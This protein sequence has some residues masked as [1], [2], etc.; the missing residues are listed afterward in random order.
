M[1]EIAEFMPLGS[2]EWLE[3]NGLGGWSSSTVSGCHTRR[4]HGLLVA[5]TEPPTG[6]MVLVSKLDETIRRGEEEWELGTSDYNGVFH[7]TGHRYWTGFCRN[8]H[9]EFLCEAGDVRIRKSVVMLHGENTV[10]LRYEV[11][12]AVGSFEL[13]FSPLLASRGYHQLTHANDAVSPAFHFE[14]GVFHAKLYQGTPEIYIGV[15]GSSFVSAPCWYYG[16]HYAMEEY[17]GLDCRE[18][19]FSPGRFAVSL[20][21]GDVLDVWLSTGDLSGRDTGSLLENELVRRQQLLDHQPAAGIGRKLALAADQFVV[22]RGDEGRTVIAGYHWFTDWGRDTMISLPGLCLSTGRYDEA[23][24]VLASFARSASRGMLPNRFPDYGEPPEYNNV[25]G[26]LWYFIAV[27]HYLEATGDNEFVLRELL[28]G[29]KD[30]VDWHFRGTRYN[31]HV[32]DSG[33]L[34]A[35]EQGQQL[36]WMDARIG[37]WVVTPRMGRPVEI[38]ALW[39]NALR[40]FSR[41]LADNGQE[42]DSRIV[43]LEA[44]KL[45]LNFSGQ[46]WYERGGWLYDVIDEQGQP[47]PTL[48]PNQLFAISLP[49]PLVTGEQAD[50]ILSV[51]KDRLYT[52]V[53]LRS[54]SPDHPGYTP[55]YRGD[56]RQRDSSYHQG[57][58]WSWLLGA[59]V[60]SLMRVRGDKREA[61]GVIDR[62]VYHLDEGCIGSVA[63]IFDA[64]PPY[65]PGGC[66]AQAWGVA[67]V[68]RVVHTY[69]LTQRN[70][71]DP[72]HKA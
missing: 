33:L 41:L 8:W 68:L 67:E 9:P 48:R 2:A 46:F 19:L 65:Q 42:A 14:Q 55:T 60:D 54:L 28:P 36:T 13:R 4:Y 26:T 57:P 5:A 56:A 31:I 30:I 3:T 20:K 29:L 62:L 50:K 23:R 25:D 27:H 1:S 35:G 6:R 45:R 44:D 18:D 16:F 72:H 10:I 69:K 12:D 7:P 58:A 47:D 63:E 39:Y 49:Y 43:D 38:Q 24:K 34:F 70:P 66:V 71:V 11:L 17:R 32:E 59:Y 52:P 22:R 53:G 37:D 15:P 64:E 51:V 40:I 21:K 61:Q